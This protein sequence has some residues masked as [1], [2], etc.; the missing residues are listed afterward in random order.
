MRNECIRDI[1]SLTTQEAKALKELLIRV[2]DHFT[3]RD[4]VLF[5]SKAREDSDEHS[6]VDI[7]VIIDGEELKGNRD[8]LSEISFEINYHYDTNIYAGLGYSHQWENNEYLELPLPSNI[9]K[10]GVVLHA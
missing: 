8:K 1:K 7:M 2:Q 4:V 9:T 6:D 3:V 10:E 5:G